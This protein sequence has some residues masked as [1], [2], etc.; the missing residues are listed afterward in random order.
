M[1]IDRELKGIKKG[2]LTKIPFITVILVYVRYSF[3]FISSDNNHIPK[4]LPIT[5]NSIMIIGNKITI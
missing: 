4:H 1:G 5:I 3:L 2:T